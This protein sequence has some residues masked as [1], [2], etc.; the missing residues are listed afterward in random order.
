MRDMTGAIRTLVLVLGLIALY[1]GGQYAMNHWT[2]WTAETKASVWVA[3][4]TLALAIVTVVSVLETRAVVRGEDRRMQQGLAPYV[5]ARFRTVMR[6]EGNEI[7]GFVFKN[8]GYG[9]ARNVS[10]RV[11]AYYSPYIEGDTYDERL[12]SAKK[13]KASMLTLDAAC[14][15]IAEK[16]PA[17]ASIS[18]MDNIRV[19]GSGI[20]SGDVLVVTARIKYLDTFGNHYETI[21]DNWHELVT[22]WIRPTNLQIGA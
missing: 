15:V 2:T 3:F 9:I 7:E 21:Y 5:T 13:A 14:D 18:L 16:E 1:G 12:E 8:S 22:R 11:E 4:G 10:I 6:N 17:S 19:Y 20:K